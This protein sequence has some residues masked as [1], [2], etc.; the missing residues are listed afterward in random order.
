MRNKFLKKIFVSLVLIAVLGVISAGCGT[1]A[2]PIIITPP[3]QTCTLT[4][5]SSCSAC[6]GYIWVNGAST[7]QYIDTNGAVTIQGLSAGTVVHVQIVDE[8][9]NFSHV[10]IK[11]L[12][13]GINIITFTYF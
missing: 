8:F 2:P 13:S 12:V 1:T 4:V 6:W 9:S 7:G 11:Q 5:Y 3:A 10:E